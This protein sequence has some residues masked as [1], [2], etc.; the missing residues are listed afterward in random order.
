M[1]ERQMY[2]L[3]GQEFSEQYIVKFE[4]PVNKTRRHVDILCLN[5][6]YNEGL[7]ELIAIEVKVR[8]W[9]RVLHQAYSHLF[10]ADNVY[11]A[12]HE[13]YIPKNHQKC[14]EFLDAVGIGLISFN[15]KANIL[16]EPRSSELINSI[17]KETIINKII[18]K[19]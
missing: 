4:F 2:K 17:R 1:R 10:F 3:I 15:G 14:E 18:A 6:K 12:L 8:D 19:L 9:K 11:I 5:K 7:S 13:K 16:K